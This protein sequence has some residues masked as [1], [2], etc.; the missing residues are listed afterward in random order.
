M[1][2]IASR[3]AW[4]VALATTLGSADWGAMQWIVGALIDGGHF[5]SARAG[6]LGTIELTAMG[7]T[8]VAIA[9]VIGRAPL[10][11]ISIVGLVIAVAAQGVSMLLAE[12]AALAAA[13]AVSGVAFGLLF[14]VAGRAG[15]AFPQ[16][17][18]AFAAAGVVSL[19]FGASKELLLGYAKQHFGYPGVFGALIVYYSVSAVPLVVLLAKDAQ[20]T[21][22]KALSLD[23]I[24]LGT[25]LPILTVMALFALATGGIFAFIQQVATRVGLDG[26]RLAQGLAVITILGTVGAVLAERVGARGT[27]PATAAA[28]LVAVGV[29]CLLVMLSPTRT[30]YWAAMLFW[31]IAYWF[32]YPLLFGMAATLDRQGR[33]ATALAAVMILASA[34]GTG[35]SGA[36]T[37][38][39]GPE[40]FGVVAL[41]AS[42]AAAMLMLLAPQLRGHAASR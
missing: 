12:F 40:S 5:S 28:G 11:T 20:P 37:S 8:L 18:R 27:R 33:L 13:R 22:P 29:S 32:C 38:Y 31:V 7:L 15:A 24:G 19:L 3:G 35:I 25:A 6:L 36:L 4:I 14:S 34:A 2:L 23:R 30:A 1:R 39:F 16:P 42:L 9:P 21:A 10:R 26:S 17:A 41:G